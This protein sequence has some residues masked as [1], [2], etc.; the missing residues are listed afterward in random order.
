MNLLGHLLFASSTIAI[1]T[2][3]AGSGLDNNIP[4]LGDASC[5]PAQPL[6]RNNPRPLDCIYA[7]TYILSIMT[8]RSRTRQFSTH[9]TP[10]QIKLPLGH[11]IGTC[12]TYVVPAQAGSP[13]PVTSSVD[14][15]VKTLLFVVGTCLL[16]NRPEAVN[17]GG[18]ATAGLN[19]GLWIVIQGTRKDG[20]STS[21]GIGTLEDLATRFWVAEPLSN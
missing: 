18:K 14:E 16:N 5:A 13:V 10:G 6:W 11:S 3:S 21:I 19:G 17:W 7:I 1:N 4:S 2:T 15:I 8:D 9:P 20:G 12:A